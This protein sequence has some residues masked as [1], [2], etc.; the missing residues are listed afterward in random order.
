MAHDADQAMPELEDVDDLPPLARDLRVLADG[1]FVFDAYDAGATTGFDDRRRAERTLERTLLPALDRLHDVMM[2][3]ERHSLLVVLQGLD[4]SGKS[5]TIKH[6]GRGFNPCR[7]NVACFKEPDE[8]EKQE[9]FLERIRRELPGPGEICFFDRSHYEDAIAPRAAGELGDD[10]LATRLKEIRE[11]E[12]ELVDNGTVVVKCLLHLSYD[13][14]RERFLRRLGR[15]D[16]QWKF[17][18]S[19]LETR[20]KWATVQGAYCEV[21]GKT[22]FDFAPWY[23]VPADHKWYRNTA[24]ATLLVDR[25]ASLRESYPGLTADADPDQLVARLQPPN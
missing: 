22:S 12:H 4:G 16:K 7:L 18:E 25:L 6:V 13:E 20:A 19:D 3:N 23:V 24:V 9:H 8:E 10:D 14:Q 11:F 17:T 1:P 15:A 2:A 5:G 21:I